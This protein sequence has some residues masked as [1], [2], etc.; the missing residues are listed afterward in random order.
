MWC[1]SS[2]VGCGRYWLHWIYV[3]NYSIEIIQPQFKHYHQK[4]FYFDINNSRFVITCFHQV[5]MHRVWVSL[6]NNPKHSKW[7]D[8]YIAVSPKVLTGQIW[9]YSW[10]WLMQWLTPQGGN[11]VFP[12]SEFNHNSSLVRMQMTLSWFFFT[13]HQGRKAKEPL[14]LPSP[15]SAN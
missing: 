9:A 12:L 10:L 6:I 15:C 7:L 3:M 5:G 4:L 11:K 13:F 8:V 14:L 2:T 1:S